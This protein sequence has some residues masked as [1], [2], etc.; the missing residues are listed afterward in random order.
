[1]TTTQPNVSNTR[2]CGTAKERVEKPAP[3]A[4]ALDWYMTFKKLPKEKLNLPTAA[5]V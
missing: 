5:K 4:Y 1:M 2:S 3:D